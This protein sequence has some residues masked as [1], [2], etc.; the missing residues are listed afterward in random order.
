M[1][2]LAHGGRCTFE[3]RGRKSDPNWEEATE[4]KRMAFS[5]KRDIRGYLHVCTAG[6]TECEIRPELTIPLSAGTGK[7]VGTFWLTP[8]SSPHETKWWS[9]DCT[10]YDSYFGLFLFSIW[11]QGAHAGRGPERCVWILARLAARQKNAKNACTIWD[12]GSALQTTVERRCRADIRERHRRAL[13]ARWP[14]GG[15]DGCAVC[16]T[17]W[18]SEWA[19]SQTQA[20]YDA[21]AAD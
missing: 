4:T 18:L 19:K 2:N 17:M 9:A 12:L 14:C 1:E 21:S 5:R 11:S 13:G 3:N 20:L 7:K 15:E 8:P 16:D 10:R 6:W